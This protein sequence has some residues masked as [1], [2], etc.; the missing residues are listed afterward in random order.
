MELLL[1]N[2]SIKD[3]TMDHSAGGQRLIMNKKKQARQID[4][5]S[6]G[7]VPEK[8]AFSNITTSCLRSKEKIGSPVPARTVMKPKSNVKSPT[9]T[10]IRTDEE[11]ALIQRLSTSIPLS[12]LKKKQQEE[13]EK[14]EKEEMMGSGQA[15]SSSSASVMRWDYHY[16]RPP[17]PEPFTK[18]RYMERTIARLQAAGRKRFEKPKPCAENLKVTPAYSKTEREEKAMTKELARMR[19]NVMAKD[20]Q[21][22]KQKEENEALIKKSLPK[23]LQESRAKNM[24]GEEKIK[25][26]YFSVHK[27][28]KQEREKLEAEFKQKLVI[29]KALQEEVQKVK[30]QEHAMHVECF[31]RRVELLDGGEE[32]LAEE[33]TTNI[34]FADD[35]GG[36]G[37]SDGGDCNRHN[38]KV[39]LGPGFVPFEYQCGVRLSLLQ[40]ETKKWVPYFCYIHMDS[41]LCHKS[42]L[43]FVPDHVFDLRQGGARVISTDDVINVDRDSRMDVD[44]LSI[45]NSHAFEVD[46]NQA[47]AT[48]IAPSTCVFACSSKEESLWWIDAVNNASTSS[49]T[50]FLI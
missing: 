11:E 5:L 14:A 43:D 42:E 45:C 41:L 2:V 16:E 24:T 38:E 26:D 19:V 46:T 35:D 40:N 17:V 23:F 9:K 32:K 48:I 36:D 21:K 7:M 22:Q 30:D 13:K 25:S 47:S 3:R 18:E 1:T 29:L 4:F 20:L 50:L 8:G 34:P 6:I 27:S 33:N 12:K 28:K 15:S 44:D 37:D 49:L 31:E 10:T 39:I